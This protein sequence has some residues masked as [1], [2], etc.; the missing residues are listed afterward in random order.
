MNTL[1][2]LN[3]LNECIDDAVSVWGDDA[4][5]SNNRFFTAYLDVRN[6]VSDMTDAANALEVMDA[7]V[8]KHRLQT[9]LSKSQIDEAVH[10][11]RESA[12]AL[13]A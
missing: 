2:T 3:I 13:T 10:V 11:W 5:V 6:A 9:Y 8:G 4:V 1:N 7:S 12:A